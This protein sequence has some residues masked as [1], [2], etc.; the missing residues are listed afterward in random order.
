VSHRSQTDQEA[1]GY[2]FIFESL[3]K[4]WKQGNSAGAGETAQLANCLMHRYKA[5]SLIPENACTMPGMVTYVYNPRA[6]VPEARRIPRACCTSYPA[7]LGALGWAVVAHAFNPS[8]WEAE[9]GGSPRDGGQ[10][11]LCSDFQDSR[12]YTERLC[13]KTKRTNQLTNQPIN[14]QSFS[15]NHNKVCDSVIKSL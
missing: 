11:G 8:T 3:G 4:S 7:C 6:E 12:D 9:A 2:S 13:L 14:N 10:P 1:N 15:P 5:L